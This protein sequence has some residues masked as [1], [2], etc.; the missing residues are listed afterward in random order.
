[1][2]WSRFNM[3]FKGK[4][5]KILLYNFASNSYLQLDKSAVS[6]IEKVREK[7]NVDFSSSPE[8]YFQLRAGGFLVEKGVDKSFI[9]ILKMNRLA[10]NYSSNQLNLTIALTKMCNFSCEYCYEQSRI[11]PRMS[12]E[13]AEDV[14]EFIKKHKRTEN[15]YI[16]WYGGEPLLEFNGLK[17]LSEQMQ[18]LEMNY[19]AQLITNGYL[20]T[21]EVINSLE[22]LKISHIQITIDGSEKTHNK[23]RS[24]RGGGKTYGQ[25]M[26]NID[27]LVRSE[28]KG[29]LSIRVN[30]DKKNSDEFIQVHQ[31][32]ENQYP[33]EME[34]Q[35]K[36]YPGFI[37]DFSYIKNNDYFTSCDKGEFLVNLSEKNRINPMKKLPRMEI[38]GCTMTKKNAYVIGPEGELY[39]CWR[40]LGIEKE[41]I[42]SIQSF[43]NWNMALIAEGMV[44]ASY[45]EEESCEKCILFPVCNGGC[46]K[47]RALNKQDNGKR[48]TCSYFKNHIEQFLRCY[49]A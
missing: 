3:M 12:H 31:L 37:D 27:R 43:T 39:K 5:K 6:L 11:P 30:V 2:E 24:L 45:L 16:T 15:L 32:I 22:E 33:Q 28:W 35:I 40:G 46:P 20:L 4:E 42:G 21:E 23:R 47:M 18:G 44:G 8:L 49:L 25:I 1:M 17:E 26:R 41:I 9:Q 14:I 13:I 7:T 34:R 10:S 48:D 29:H 38:E 19:N 36:L